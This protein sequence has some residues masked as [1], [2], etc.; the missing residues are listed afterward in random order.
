MRIDQN[1]IIRS[2]Y[3]FVCSKMDLSLDES[4]VS[5]DALHHK[6]W[7]VQAND[8]S[9][10]HKRCFLNTTASTS[11][12]AENERT[13]ATIRLAAVHGKMPSIL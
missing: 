9:E 2:A 12:Q 5:V 13:T 11:S 6:F 3:L 4:K 1:V 8:V 10:Y 7:S